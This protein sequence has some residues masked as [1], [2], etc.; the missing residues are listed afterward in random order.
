VVASTVDGEAQTPV[1]LHEWRGHGGAAWMSFSVASWAQR[2]QGFD[3]GRV[4]RLRARR[5]HE[6]SEGERGRAWGGRE[7]SG[8]CQIL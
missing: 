1:R 6:E 4:T 3:G 7:R 2:E 5:E 8:L